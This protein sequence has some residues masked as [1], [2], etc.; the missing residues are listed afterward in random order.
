MKEE[1]YT[2]WN[3]LYQAALSSL[4]AR[5]AKVEH[6]AKLLENDFDLIGSTGLEDKLQ[7][8]VPDTIEMIRK[9]GINLWVLTG[10]KIETAVNI[11]YSCKLLDDG[12][13]QYVIDGVRSEDVYKQL[14][15]AEN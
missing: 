6:C 4:S 8:G 7:D 2:S 15:I 5:D 1:D 3:E 14:C 11:G 9:A 10:D 13:N 12:I